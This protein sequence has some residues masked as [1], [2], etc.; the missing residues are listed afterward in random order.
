[1]AALVLAVLA[2]NMARQLLDR[3]AARQPPQGTFVGINV[4]S[5]KRSR[6]PGLR[7]YTVRSKL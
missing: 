3:S 2:I 6:R 5:G 7:P 4:A 1:M